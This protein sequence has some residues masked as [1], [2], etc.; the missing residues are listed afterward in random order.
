MT[1]SVGV[2]GLANYS[3]AAGTMEGALK[4]VSAQREIRGGDINHSAY[5]D[6]KVFFDFL[7]P[8]V[9]SEQLKNPPASANALFLARSIGRTKIPTFPENYAVGTSRLQQ[10]CDFFR[11]LRNPR[12]LNPE[13]THTTNELI[14]FFRGMLEYGRDESTCRHHDGLSWEERMRSSRNF[15]T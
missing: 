1:K 7:R 2:V 10:Y 3:Y 11:E 4:R 12:Q 6:L 8:S 5:V 9:M 13:E 15:F 14:L